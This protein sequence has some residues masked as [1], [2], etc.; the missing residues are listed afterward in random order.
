MG[1]KRIIKK[2]LCVHKFENSVE[3]GQ[4]LERHNLSKLTQ[5]K[6]NHLNR[7]ISIN[8]IELIVNNLQ[9]RKYKP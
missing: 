5:E 3:M 7:P 9:N 1:I 8:K 6:I 4:F 2:Q